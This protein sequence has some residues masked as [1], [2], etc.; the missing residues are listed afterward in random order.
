MIT[1]KLQTRRDRLADRGLRSVAWRRRCVGWVIDA[2]GVRVAARVRVA[3]ATYKFDSVRV[4][5]ISSGFRD[6]SKK[7]LSLEKVR[8]GLGAQ[9]H[10]DLG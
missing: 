10:L 5:D 4:I 8:Q 3:G 6:I 2:A 9:K 1:P 7:K